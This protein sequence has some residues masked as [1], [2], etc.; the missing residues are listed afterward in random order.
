MLPAR[1]GV[2]GFRLAL[3]LVAAFILYLATKQ[4]PVIEAVNDKI[5]HT[6][7]FGALALLAD[8]AF[9]R[10][11]F[12]WPKWLALLGFGVFIEFCQYFLPWR[13]ASFFDVMADGAGIAAYAAGMPLL[14]RLPLLSLLP[15]YRRHL[16][17]APSLAAPARP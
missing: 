13:E 3:V 9:P 10:S 6:L 7:A 11:A 5:K 15:A 16:A 1:L 12:G 8:F 17:G 2:A 14:D 4:G